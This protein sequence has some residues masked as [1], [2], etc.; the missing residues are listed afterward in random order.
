MQNLNI[1]KNA[2]VYTHATD[3][4]MMVLIYVLYHGFVMTMK[5]KVLKQ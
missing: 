2:K 5:E 1:N 3:V 4:N